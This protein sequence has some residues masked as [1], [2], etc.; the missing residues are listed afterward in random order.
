M[1]VL[2]YTIELPWSKI[3]KIKRECFLLL[4]LKSFFCF[5]IKEIT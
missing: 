5:Y 4:I 3:L 2:S 1:K